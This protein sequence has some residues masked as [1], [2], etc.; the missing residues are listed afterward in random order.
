MKSF[1]I[2]FVVLIEFWVFV[3]C[4]KRTFRL[5][6]MPCSDAEENAAQFHG[7]TVNL[8]DNK[9]GLNGT[10]VVDRD[11]GFNATLEVSDT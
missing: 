5:E 4:A 1:V 6:V 8:G 11:L 10:L 9:F 3:S 7:Q 2:I